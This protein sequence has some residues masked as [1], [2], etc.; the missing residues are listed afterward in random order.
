LNAIW[1]SNK[2]ED[3]NSFINHDIRKSKTTLPKRLNYKL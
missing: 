2:W 1:E 3:S